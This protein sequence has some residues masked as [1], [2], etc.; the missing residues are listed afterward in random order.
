MFDR[1]SNLHALM[2]AYLRMLVA[3][4]DEARLDVEPCPGGNPP[5]WIL[6]HLAVVGDGA[7]RLLG[8]RLSLPASWHRDFG[9]GSKPGQADPVPSK[10]E[11]MRAIESGHARVT[12]AA[13]SARPE[14]MDQPHGVEMAIL[15]DSPVRTRADLLAHLMTTHVAAHLGQLSAWR[16][17][18]GLPALF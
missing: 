10:Q 14:D 8:L 1:E 15:K 7:G 6:G 17:Q 16:R 12:E 11:L 4:I 9:P 18:M 5:R 3:D 2:L 13:R